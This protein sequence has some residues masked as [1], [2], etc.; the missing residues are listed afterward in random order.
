[1]SRSTIFEVLA[2]SLLTALEAV[3]VRVLALSLTSEAAL[4][5]LLQ[6]VLAAVSEV[7][8]AADMST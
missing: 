3:S 7:G 5:T 1:M 2:D 4:L 8:R 6:A